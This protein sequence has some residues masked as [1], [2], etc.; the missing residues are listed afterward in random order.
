MSVAQM[1]SRSP[2]QH[3]ASGAIRSA[4]AGASPEPIQHRHASSI[5][6]LPGHAKVITSPMGPLQDQGHLSSQSQPQP[7][8]PSQQQQ[9]QP[10]S[11]QQPSQPQLRSASAR[12]VAQAGK[13]PYWQYS[14]YQTPESDDTDGHEWD[15][16]FSVLHNRPYC[17]NRH[18]C[19]ST[20][21][22]FC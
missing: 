15:E 17:E 5:A 8:Q 14:G 16:F 2:V 13:Q 21:F 3:I 18:P 20:A 11:Q 4:R 10:P 22:P 1:Q 9:Q 12:R 19:R 7:Q 6:S